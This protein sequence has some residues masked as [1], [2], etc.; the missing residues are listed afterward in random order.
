MGSWLIYKP[1]INLIHGDKELMK[2]DE[3]EKII[4]K[5]DTETIKISE[6]FDDG[7]A[8]RPWPRFHRAVLNQMSDGEATIT[9]YAIW[10]NT[11]RDN[12]H[13]AYKMINEGKSEDAKSHLVRV[14]NSLSAFSD[15]QK[16]MDDFTR[17]PR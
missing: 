3:L 15:V 10:A 6:A 7:G 12:A 1:V 17:H 16:G 5:Y 14:I 2:E 13:L 4:A 8:D 11:V 9:R